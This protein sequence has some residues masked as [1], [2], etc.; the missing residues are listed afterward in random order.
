M[1]LGNKRK[2][3]IIEVTL[4]NGEPRKVYESPDLESSTA[5]MYKPMR[6]DDTGYGVVCESLENAILFMFQTD[7]EHKVIENDVVSP[8]PHKWTPLPYKCIICNEHFCYWDK[9]NLH[10]M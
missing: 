7:C 5:M 1:I 2:H 4:P 9:T 10:K 3:K 8:E 6:M